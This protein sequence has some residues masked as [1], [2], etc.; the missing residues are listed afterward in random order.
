MMSDQR[1]KMYME[2]NE[3]GEMWNREQAE[4]TNTTLIGMRGAATT[5]DECRRIQIWMEP[6]WRARLGGYRWFD[7]KRGDRPQV[8]SRR[9]RGKK[10]LLRKT[11]RH[12]GQGRNICSQRSVT[13]PPPPPMA[14]ARATGTTVSSQATPRPEPLAQPNVPPLARYRQATAP[15]SQG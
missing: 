4:S 12:R 10:W 8:W 6:R 14:P 13:S 7:R 1:R 2:D 15:R 5:S 11:G 3:N 9:G